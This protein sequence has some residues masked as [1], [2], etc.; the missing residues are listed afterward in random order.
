MM[1]FLDTVRNRDNEPNE[2]YGRE[3]QELFTLGVKDLLGNANYEQEDVVQIARAFTG[4]DYDD[5]GVAEFAR[6]PARLRGRL[7]GA[8]TEGDLQDRG[9]F[10]PTGSASTPAPARASRRSTPSSTSSSSTATGP[11]LRNTVADHIAQQADHLLR[12]SDRRR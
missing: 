5:K 2:N 12:P 3:L 9:G 7:P 10:G 4:W 8:R 1:E 6:R 11:A